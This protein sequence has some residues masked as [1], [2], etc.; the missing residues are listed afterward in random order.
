MQDRAGPAKIPPIRQEG[1][2]TNTLDERIESA[3]PTAN[4]RKPNIVI[5]FVS[6]KFLILRSNT[7][8]YLENPVSRFPFDG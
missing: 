7:S 6:K 4:G 5:K 8:V 2:N 1:I 3:T